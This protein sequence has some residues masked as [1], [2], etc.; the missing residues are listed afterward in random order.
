MVASWELWTLKPKLWTSKIS[1]L[2][3]L[4][5][6]FVIVLVC[7]KSLKLITLEESIFSVQQP[8][9][10]LPLFFVFS[11]EVLN[12]GTKSCFDEVNQQ[13]ICHW[14]YLAYVIQ[15]H[16]LLLWTGH[17]SGYLFPALFAN[18][19]LFFFMSVAHVSPA[20]FHLL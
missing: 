8:A 1:I 3:H 12:S 19:I 18:Q 20:P 13:H 2:I 6:N 7:A 17:D 14:C 15:V 11:S 5:N 9:L 10:C 4:I 16:W